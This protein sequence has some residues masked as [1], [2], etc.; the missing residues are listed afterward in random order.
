[1][2]E[3]NSAT[4]ALQAKTYILLFLM[5][6]LGSVGNTVLDKGMKNLGPVDF[7]SRSAIWQGLFHTFTNGTIW[8]GILFMLLFMVCHM[9]V[10]SWADYSFVMLFSALTYALV[11]L[12]GY[13]WLKEY[14]PVAR[15]FGI[16]LIIFGVFLV[17]RTPPRTTQPISGRSAG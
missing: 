2:D 5:M 3:S 8:L 11:P 7:S 1:M 6:A 12:L 15:R 13:I 14:V 16:I 9:L 4:R 17:S 10:L